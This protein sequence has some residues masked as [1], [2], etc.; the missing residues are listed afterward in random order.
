M[1]KI[2]DEGK[3][4]LRLLERDQCTAS[5]TAARIQGSLGIHCWS[6]DRENT[7]H[8]YSETVSSLGKEGDSIT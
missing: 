2:T 6:L 5:F 3:F 1:K 8:R 7:V 4:R